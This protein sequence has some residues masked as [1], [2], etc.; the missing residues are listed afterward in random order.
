MDV[1]FYD[2]LL[3]IEFNLT[4]FNVHIVAHLPHR[5]STVAESNFE[6]SIHLRSFR[7]VS[8]QR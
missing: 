2:Y 5:K 7:R 6:A 8:D 3:A 4:L 1:L